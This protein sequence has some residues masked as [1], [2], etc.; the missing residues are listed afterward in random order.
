MITEMQREMVIQ[1]LLTDSY[2]II[3]ERRKNQLGGKVPIA[4]VKIGEP[5]YLPVKGYLHSI[6]GI[7]VKLSILVE[8]ADDT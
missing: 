3:S 2:K 7:P 1:E 8:D 4:D 6:Y 5:L